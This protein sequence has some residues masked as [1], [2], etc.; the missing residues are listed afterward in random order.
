MDYQ[1]IRNILGP[2]TR[3]QST[4][5][6]TPELRIEV[7]FDKEGVFKVFKQT[8]DGSSDITSFNSL[9]KTVE[10]L[11]PWFLPKVG[12]VYQHINGNVYTVIAIANE[13]SERPEYPPTVVYQGNNGLVW[14]KPLTNF[15]R[16]MKRI[17]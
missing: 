6:C 5:L 7:Q 8:R 2:L 4:V 3:G 16:K 11:V 9:R 14:A 1:E 10:F 15:Q 17:K 12:N 13:H